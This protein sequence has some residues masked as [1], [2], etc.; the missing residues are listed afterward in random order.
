MIINH[1]E[2]AKPFQIE[3][4]SEAFVC[5]VTGSSVEPQSV[6]DIEF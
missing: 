5:F 2:G 4:F 3:K 6:P 1:C